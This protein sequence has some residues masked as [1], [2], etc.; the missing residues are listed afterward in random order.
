M[1]TDLTNEQIIEMHELLGSFGDVLTDVPG[2]TNLTEHT[3]EVTSEVPIRQKPYRLPHSV[4]AEVEKEI[5]QLLDMGIIEKSSSP[6][7]SPIVV[8]PKKPSGIRMCT[9]YRKLNQVTVA[10]AYPIPRIDE[11]LD[12]LGQAKFL[13][14]ID[15]TKGYYQVPL[16]ENAKAKFAF[17]SPYGHFQYTT[18]PFGMKNSS[19]A[20]SSWWTQQFMV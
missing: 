13:T 9:D 8:V 1:S 10:N 17:V 11:M 14:T 15:L 3:L 20:F 16:S 12:E 19:A 2:R 5:Q 7:A 6:W 4:K 18:V